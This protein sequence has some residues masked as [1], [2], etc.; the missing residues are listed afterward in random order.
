MKFP[1]G[2][3]IKGIQRTVGKCSNPSESDP[4]W[5]GFIFEVRDRLDEYDTINDW[6]EDYGNTI[7]WCYR[8]FKGGSPDII[9]GE[10]SLWYGGYAGDDISDLM[11]KKGNVI[12]I[13]SIRNSV[14]K[15]HMEQIAVYIDEIKYTIQ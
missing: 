11:I 5:T 4:N 6:E 14:Q 13:D 7:T 9:R 1:P 10:F 8:D 12:Y 15:T 3:Y 2:Y